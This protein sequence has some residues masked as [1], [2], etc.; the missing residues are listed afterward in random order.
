[1]YHLEWSMH[2]LFMD[3]FLVSWTDRRERENHIW[4]SSSVNSFRFGNGHIYRYRLSKVKN[5]D[6]TRKLTIVKSV[7]IVVHSAK[8]CAANTV[9]TH[10]QKYLSRYLLFNDI[11]F[12]QN[13]NNSENPT[14]LYSCWKAFVEEV[15]RFGEKK[16]SHSSFILPMVS[17]SCIQKLR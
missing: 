11:L 12:S 8:F 4:L 9:S 15:S 17:C 6:D 7:K 16:T 10:T 1:M 2:F 3:Y 14:K 5:P 13:Y